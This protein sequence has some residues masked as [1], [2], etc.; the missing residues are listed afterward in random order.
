MAAITAA[1][2][3]KLREV[4]GVGMMDCKKALV[5]TDGDFD[6]AIKYL[7]EKGLSKAA[8]KA[9]RETK[10]GLI[11]S[12]IHT[13][14]TVGAMIEVNCETDFVARTDAFQTLC[15]DLCMQ[16]VATCPLTVTKDE[17]DEAT[18]AAEAEIAKNKA[19]NEGK[20]EKIIDKIVEGVV[21]KF[22][23]ENA[24]L[25][26]PFIKD[27]DKKVRDYINEAIIALGENIQVSRFVRMSLGE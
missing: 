17:I 22:R 9:D 5:E 20:P 4:T 27:N 2:V 8:K 15:K 12:Y 7:R 16:I 1:N 26:Q 23:E 25:E 10:E 11:Y 14:G 21:S 3:M 6:A 13:N 19:I 24:L 18:I